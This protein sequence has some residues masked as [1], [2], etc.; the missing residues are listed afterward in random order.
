M[1]S[2]IDSAIY[3]RLTSQA[4]G[5]P[6]QHDG[7]K[8]DALTG[9]YI[10]AT[11]VPAGNSAVTLGENGEN[12]HGGFLQLDLHFTHGNGRRGITQKA[13]ELAAIFK[14]GSREIYG[15]ANVEFRETQRSP[16]RR[17]GGYLVLVLSIN[18]AAWVQR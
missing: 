18:W 1:F 10:R 8:S 6:V 4:L 9:N 13:D 5:L 12:E 14:E 7:E 2:D 3:K 15:G 16:L 11:I 17:E